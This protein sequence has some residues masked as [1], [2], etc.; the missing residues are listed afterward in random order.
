MINNT[1]S[2][3]SLQIKMLKKR[4]FGLLIYPL[5]LIPSLCAQADTLRI[6]VASN[7]VKTAQALAD[8]FKRQSG[9]TVYLSSG[10][11]GKLYLQISKGAPFDLF[12]SADKQKP[13]TLVVKGFALAETKQTYAI[14]KL[15]LWL[16]SCR[17]SPQLNLLNKPIISKIAIANP[18]LA[19]YGMASRQLL[20]NEQLWKAVKEKLVYSE[21]ISQVSQLAKLGVVDAAF[22]AASHQSILQKEKGGCFFEPDRYS[23][24]AIE[25]QLVIIS[26]SKNRALAEEF[27]QFLAIKDT[28][29]LIKN[30]GYFLPDSAKMP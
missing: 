6:G 3:R 9:H 27:I 7:F 19:P 26:S 21:N 24:P 12:L 18:K 25:Q 4:L 2:L 17:S 8:E 23:Y 1:N 20:K 29:N 15:L 5:V 22:I 16:K 11:S 30:M 10:S 13:Q 28:Q 14:G